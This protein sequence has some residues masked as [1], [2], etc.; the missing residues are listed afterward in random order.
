MAI[1]RPAVLEI[2]QLPIRL[3]V[4]AERRSAG[5]DGLGQNRSNSRDEPVGASP[6]DGCGEASRRHTGA[7]QRLADIDIAES[8]NDPL[9]EQR[10]FDRGYLARELREKVG[11]IEFS[12]ERLRA[13]PGQQRVLCRLVALYI[14]EQTEATCVVE[15]NNGAVVEPQHHVV[16]RGVGQGCATRGH[17][18]GHAEVEQQQAIRIELDQDVLPAAAER[19]DPGAF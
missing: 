10:R 14:V 5:L 2:A 17:S 4:V 19:T 11:T 6:A 15:A 3:N 9:I 12:F 8:G 18:A 16:V 7:E 1:D 13:E